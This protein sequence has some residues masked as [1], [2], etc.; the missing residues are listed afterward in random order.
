MRRLKFLL[1]C[2][3]LQAAKAAAAPSAAL[4]VRFD[5]PDG[6]VLAAEFH[7]ASRAERRPAVLLLHQAGSSRREWD[8]LVPELLAQGIGV[9]TLDLRGHGES[10]PA[11][12]GDAFYRKLFTDPDFAPPDVEA[13][14]AWLKTR[15]EADPSRIGVVGGSVGANLAFVAAGASW[16][17]R[18]AIILSGNH[19]NANLLAA[20]IVRFAPANVF[21][22]AAEQ[23]PGRAQEARRMFE[24]AGEDRRLRILGRSSAHG[25][26]L[27]RENPALRREA[28]GWLVQSL[29]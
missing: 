3:L 21:V 17:V 25:V 26:S 14:L 27:L 7:A 13:A 6:A 2:L 20:R 29:Q 1:P 12:D 10:K 24:Q 8:F 19:K 11:A 23:D 28:L 16:G 18:A 22:L 5:R 9:L 15:P 4:A